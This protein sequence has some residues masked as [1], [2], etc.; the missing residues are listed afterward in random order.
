MRTEIT[1][2]ETAERFNKEHKTILTMVRTISVGDKNSSLLFK[3]SEFTTS[4][5]KKYTEYKMGINGFSVLSGFG[6]LSR[7]DEAYVKATILNEFG[8]KFSVHSV[9]K[10]RSEDLFYE[11]LK[12]FMPNQEIIRQYPIGR[13]KVDFYIASF[14]LVVEYDESYHS[15]KSTEES[16]QRRFDEINEYL[17]HETDDGIDMVRV[18]SSN[19]EIGL[20]RIVG[21]MAGMFANNINKYYESYSAEFPKH[22]SIKFREEKEN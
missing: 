18:K 17:M 4:Q 11:K 22:R 8:E 3:C 6:S 5:N 12:R 9:D 10:K 14:G 15:A 7:S 21:Y 1:T 2:R 16:D 20:M 13:Y 19:E